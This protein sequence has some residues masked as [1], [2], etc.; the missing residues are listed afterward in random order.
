MKCAT[1]GC[2]REV[3]LKNRGGRPQ[4]YCSRACDQA[5][6]CAIWKAAR[7]ARALVVRKCIT[8]GCLR[9]A[10]RNFRGLGP[11]T[12]YCSK[13]CGQRHRDAIRYGHP[14]SVNVPTGLGRVTEEILDGLGHEP[15]VPSRRPVEYGFLFE[16]GSL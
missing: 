7:L 1:P 8:P 2:D 3:V 6:R 14:N 4:K 13:N 9:D 10:R 16:E 15:A 11:N 5:R 12:K